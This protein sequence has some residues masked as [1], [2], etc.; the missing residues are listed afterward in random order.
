MS[1]LHLL[2]GNIAIDRGLIMLT[3]IRME[4][5]HT[6]RRTIKARTLIL[7]VKEPVATWSV[8]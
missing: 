3:I 2:Q 6:I 7:L 5:M 8:T 1:L 4:I